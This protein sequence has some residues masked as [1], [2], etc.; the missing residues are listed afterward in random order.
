M[1]SLV[2]HCELSALIGNNQY[3]NRARSTTK[4]LLQTRPEM[5]LINNLESLLD[6]PSLRHCNELAVL[7]D[8]NEPVLF[9]NRAKKGVKDNGRRGMGNHTWLLVELLGEQINTK[10]TVLAS[11][12]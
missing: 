6:F 9:E 4:G 2:I 10:V 1:N 8:I 5:S 3:T 7:S 11:L 12:G